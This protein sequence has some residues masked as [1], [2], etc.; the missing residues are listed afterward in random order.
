M[1]TAGIKVLFIGKSWTVPYE[2]KVCENIS[3]LFRDIASFAPDVLVTSE[4][5][6]GA[7]NIAGLE[8]RK[9]W[10]H[11]NPDASDDE[12]T[13]A[14]D[15]CYIG[16]LFGPH[17]LDESLP[18][19]SIY[20]PTYNTGDFLRDTYQS[21]REQTYPNWEWCV[22]DD[23]S[24]DGTWQ[25]LLELA[26]EDYRVRPMQIKHSGKI[27][28][29]KDVATR[30]ANGRYLIELDHDDMLTDNA[31]EEV[32]QAFDAHPEVGMVYSNCASF[33]SDGS[34]HMFDGDFWKDRYRDTE[35]RGKIYRECL[36]PDI[37]D[38]FGP[39]HHQLFGWFLTVGPNHVRA[40]RAD[41]LRSL[42]GYNRNFPVADDWELYARFFLH[43]KCLHLD[44][45]LYLYRFH[46]AASNTTFT[47]NKSI[48]DH[49]ELGRRHHA[50]EF[51]EY[52]KRRQEMS[53]DSLK[54]S[55]NAE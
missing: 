30:M 52:N 16:T 13:L 41:T 29:L 22:V 35:Y 48:Q 9:K 10:I 5:A 49:L 17:H 38:S 15:S 6:P 28:H 47:R 33:F 25:K 14:I 12:V 43:S 40:Y 39:E 53:E 37:Y 18:L 8:L 36:N 3:G 27:G 20:T 54:D 32:R 4:F 11:I 50:A 34:P 1:P 45:M 7:L 44:K 19:I 55:E 46:D 23:E 31:V 51:I 42:G 2:V 24:S 21:L 26:R